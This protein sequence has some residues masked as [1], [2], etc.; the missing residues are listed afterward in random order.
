M[1]MTA[2]KSKFTLLKTMWMLLSWSYWVRLSLGHCWSVSDWQVNQH[3]W[4]SVII[5][6]QI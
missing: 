1:Q 4:W 6:T 2:V 5:F 3:P